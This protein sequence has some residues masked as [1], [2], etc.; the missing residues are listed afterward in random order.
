[1]ELLIFGGGSL[2]GFA[3]KEEIPVEIDVVFINAPQLGEPKRIDG[4]DE[5][6]FS[7]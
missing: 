4:V 2:V 7:H 1:M 3:R 6:E 5:K